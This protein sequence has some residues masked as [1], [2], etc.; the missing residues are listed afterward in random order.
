MPKEGNNKIQCT[1]TGWN[2]IRVSESN[3]ILMHILFEEEKYPLS[4]LYKMI[5]CYLC[6]LAWFFSLSNFFFFAS[7]LNV[8][9]SSLSVLAHLFSS[10]LWHSLYTQAVCVCVY[11]VKLNRLNSTDLKR[12]KASA[13]TCSHLCKINAQTHKMSE[14]KKNNRANEWSAV[15]SGSEGVA[16]K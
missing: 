7:S 1:P 16:S 14:M 11:V 9:H 15:R 13:L 6:R 8:N 10:L 2:E 5:C 3:N 12:L 4:I